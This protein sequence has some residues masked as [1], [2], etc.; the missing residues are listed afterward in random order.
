MR[1]AIA[2]PCIGSSASALRISR[3]RVPW[4]MSIGFMA[5]IIYNTVVDKQ[6]DE[7]NGS[8]VPF[9]PRRQGEPTRTAVFT[10]KE[11]ALPSGFLRT[12]TAREACCGL[13]RPRAV[14]RGMLRVRTQRARPRDRTVGTELARKNGVG[15]LALLD[16]PSDDRGPVDRIGSRTPCAVQH[17]GHQE[18]AEVLAQPGVTRLH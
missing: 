16:P 9:H 17:P 14:V 5:M 7:G 1:A 15:C 18:Q 13:D 2:H 6:V 11:P 4:T 3:S 12:V 10:S 8:C